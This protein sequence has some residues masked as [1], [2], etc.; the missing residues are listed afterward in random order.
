MSEIILF[1]DLTRNISRVVEN[2]K[3]LC[4]YILNMQIAPFLSQ[5]SICY[6]VSPFTEIK[7][8]ICGKYINLN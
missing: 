8:V 2:K 3:G 7:V 5:L 1:Q 4:A 6:C